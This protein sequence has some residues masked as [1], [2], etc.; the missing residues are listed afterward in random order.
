[1]F[2]LFDEKYPLENYNDKYNFL[3]MYPY[4]KKYKDT[5]GSSTNYIYDFVGNLKDFNDIIKDIIPLKKTFVICLKDKYIQYD[6]I[7]NNKIT[8]WLIENEF[9]KTYIGKDI[10]FQK[11][12]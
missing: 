8:T 2:W 11:V 12:G 6:D 3:Q 10:S 4:F 5:N 9:I 7:E 1:M